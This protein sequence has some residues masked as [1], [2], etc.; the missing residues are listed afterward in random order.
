MAENKLPRP[1]S[2]Q[3]YPPV[4]ILHEPASTE[5]LWRYMDFTVQTSYGQLKK[6]LGKLDEWKS[7]AHLYLTKVNYIDYETETFEG[8][9]AEVDITPFFHKRKSFEHEKEFR[10]IIRPYHETPEHILPPVNLTLLFE[11]IYISP[12]APVWFKV[13]VSNVLT[14][15]GLNTNIVHHSELENDPIF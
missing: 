1:T 11:N 9:V 4:P 5:K 12:L 10:I 15:Y 14:T 7:R 3:L 2:G 8:G 6:S 13:L